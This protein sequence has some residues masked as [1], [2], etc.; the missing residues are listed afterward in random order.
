MDYYDKGVE[1][2][3]ICKNKECKTIN[4]PKDIE[5]VFVYH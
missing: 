1:A 3:I 4:L 2:E 5:Y